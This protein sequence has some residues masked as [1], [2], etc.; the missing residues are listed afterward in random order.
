ATKD[1]ATPTYF[2]YTTR[3]EK[4]Y[5]WGGT[6]PIWT[7]Y[8]NAGRLSKLHTYRDAAGNINFY[9]TS[10]PAN[11]GT[12]DTTTWLYHPGTELVQQKLDAANH[13]PT[14]TYDVHGRLSGRVNADTGATVVW[15]HNLA[16]LPVSIGHVLVAYDSKGRLPSIGADLSEGD[17]FS[18]T[19][20]YAPDLSYITDTSTSGDEVTSLF[21]TL[22]RRTGVRY[23]YNSL[24]V[25]EDHWNYGTNSGKMQSIS[26]TGGLANWGSVT[27]AYTPST[28]WLEK[29]TFNNSTSQP[30]LVTAK[31][32]DALWRLKTTNTTRGDGTTA[33][34]TTLGKFDYQ[35]G[36][37]NGDAKQRGKRVQAT[38]G[39]RA[40]WRYGFNDRGEVTSG[41]KKWW[42]GLEEPVA[43]SQFAY[44]FDAIGNRTSTTVNGQS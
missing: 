14:F 43:G 33:L 25:L 29:L 12:G 38:L 30:I 8:D 4:A 27:A 9:G 39:N 36:P 42:G 24:L 26:S 31:T 23:K 22:G 2:A 19:I 20:V 7:E 15:N 32:P 11:A 16:G 28:D 6:Y 18:H 3:G 40:L 35:Y 37:M 21:D 1:G 34:P 41:S 44:N 5:T 10:W 17:G 13:G